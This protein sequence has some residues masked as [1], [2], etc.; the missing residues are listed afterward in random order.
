MI[1][2]LLSYVPEFKRDVNETRKEFDI[3]EDG[4]EWGK[5]E[6]YEWADKKDIWYYKGDESE[7]DEDRTSRSD[8]DVIKNFPANPFENKMLNL[9]TKYKLP[10]NF[11]AYP[12]RGLPRFILSGQIEV[13][14]HNFA[15]E[16]HEAANKSIWLSLTAFV[17][18]S[19][20][21]LKEAISELK[22]SM[23]MLPEFFNGIDTISKKR[24]RNNIIRDLVLLEAQT[25]RSGK[26]K[27]IKKYKPGS[28]MDQLSK[29]K[30]ISVKKWE[31]LH[32]K[33]I[34]VEYDNQTSR[35][36]G[37]KQGLKGD[38]VRQ[39]KKRLNSLSKELFGYDLEL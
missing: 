17:P 20:K 14:H 34:F 36:I 35:Q 33:D 32:K 6:L 28:Y 26:P 12:Y 18:L 39:A 15:I 5:N 31:Q 19:A 21:E 8:E 1:M 4:F 37:K 13:S 23:E 2:K 10:F 9:G 38:A 7:P 3:K 24:Y 11:Y 22:S 25:N 16:I 27:R 30:T 29:S